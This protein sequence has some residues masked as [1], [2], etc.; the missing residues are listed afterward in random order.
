MNPWMIVRRIQVLLITMIFLAACASRQKGAGT[1]GMPDTPVGRRFPVLARV[2]AGITYLGVSSRLDLLAQLARD[3]TRLIPIPGDMFGAS[4]SA[5]SLMDEQFRKGLGMSPLSP[6]DLAQ[7]GFAVDGSA[8]VFSTGVYPTF[9]LPVA[10]RARVEKLLQGA[11][12]KATVTVA[13]RRGTAYTSYKDGAGDDVVS[14]ALYEGWLIVHLGSASREKSPA[15]LDQVLDARGAAAADADVRWAFDQA[16]DRRQLL[17][18]VRAPALGDAIRTLIDTEGKRA[19]QKCAAL[20]QRAAGTLGRIAF[21][22]ALHE[23][24]MDGLALVELSKDAS[25]AIAGHLAAPP[26]AAYLAARADAG[27]YLSTALDLDW[28]SRL[29]REFGR[30]DCGSVWNALAEL[31]LW[32]LSDPFEA[33]YGKRIFSSYHAAI[34]GARVSGRSLDLQSDAWLGVADATS[35][36]QLLDTFV[37]G[38]FRTQ[39]KVGTATV[40]RLDLSLFS[41]AEPIDLV[42]QRDVL[43]LASGRGMIE[44]LL[45][46]QQQAPGARELFSFGFR[47]EKFP[48]LAAPLRWIASKLGQSEGSADELAL[49]LAQFKWFGASAVLTAP[50][51]QVTGGFELR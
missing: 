50:G 24:H 3:L 38:P 15:W 14:F 33:L 23:A 42:P 30:N 26:T 11:T 8:A 16:G 34:L 37:V 6:A 47:A 44:R 19:D 49:L 31:D 4:R 43:R 1:L 48:D 7:H 39:R 46:P 32:Q 28:T 35:L 20:D 45:A 40:T 18:L 12:R 17:G 25:Q 9:V 13:E 51:I 29:A 10:D 22:G 21:A 36:E 2:P 27:F 41:I 5:T